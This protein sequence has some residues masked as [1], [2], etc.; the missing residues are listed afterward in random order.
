MKGEFG[1]TT[2]SLQF[3]NSN[4][5]N[6]KVEA[7]IDAATITTGD[8]QRDAHRKSPDLFDVDK[9]PAQAFKSV[10]VSKKGEEELAVAGD[11]TIRGVTRP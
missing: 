1:A 11:L 7:S 3:D 9:F 6:S 2:G 5:A 4:L 10:H 8:A